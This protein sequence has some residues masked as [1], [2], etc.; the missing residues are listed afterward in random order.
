MSI[1][2]NIAIVIFVIQLLIWDQSVL[3]ESKGMFSSFKQKLDSSAMGNVARMAS[4]DRAANVANAITSLKLMEQELKWH[5]LDD[6][7][8]GGR[9]ET[10]LQVCTMT[11]L[12]N[13]Q[14]TINTNGGGF[15]SIRTPIPTLSDDITAIRIRYRG[16]GKTYKVLISNGQGMRAP[17]WQSDLATTDNQSGHGTKIQ[18]I[19]LPLNQFKPSF[20]PK[21]VSD[22]DLAKY[23]LI[24]SEMKQLGFMLSLKLTDG[25]PNPEETYGK[26][27][28]DFSLLIE[29]IDVVR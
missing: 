14:G 28:F 2:I 5:R 8:M 24:P 25:S 18:E 4:Y 16:D 29:S 26:G 21:A 23:K 17:S 11:G 6:G 12:L 27:I 13:F 3:V 22:A 15:T 7:V 10:A 20:G 19:I 1:S 9:S